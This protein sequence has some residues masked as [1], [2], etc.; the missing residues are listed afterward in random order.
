MSIKSTNVLLGIA[1]MATGSLIIAHSL[2][3]GF[4][5][6]MGIYLALVGKAAFSEAIR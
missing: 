4:W 5:L 3:Y 1:A 2:G 6:S